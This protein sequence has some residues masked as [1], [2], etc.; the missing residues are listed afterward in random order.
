MPALRRKRVTVMKYKYV[1]LLLGPVNFLLL[2][3]FSVRVMVGVELVEHKSLGDCRIVR[4]AILY[5]V[6]PMTGWWTP[7]YLFK[8]NNF[9]PRSGKPPQVDLW[10][11]DRNIKRKQGEL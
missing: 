11:R 2:Q 4:R 5:G 10:V 7:Y 9:R 6:I 3:W 8:V 1:R